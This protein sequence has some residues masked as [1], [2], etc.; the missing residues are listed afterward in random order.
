MN[1]R[2]SGPPAVEVVPPLPAQLTW[3]VLLGGVAV[4]AV[5][6]LAGI[7]IDTLA[8]MNQPPEIAERLKWANGQAGP[9]SQPGSIGEVRRIHSEIGR[10][11]LFATV[12]IALVAVGVLAVASGLWLRGGSDYR[13]WL[14]AAAGGWLGGFG[15]PMHWDSI[16][17][18]LW[19]AG[20]AAAAGGGLARLPVRWR[21]SLLA[22][23]VLF[24]FGSI[25]TAVTAPD[26]QGRS[27]WLSIMVGGR[28]YSSYSRFLYLGNAYHFY[29]PDPGPATQFVLL[30]EYEIDDPNEK[31]GK[32]TSVE[33]VTLPRRQANYRDPLGLTYFR[34]LSL[35]ELASSSLP[36][37][38]IPPSWEKAAVMQRRT[39]NELDKTGKQVVV[40]GATSFGEVDMTQYRQ[41]YSPIRRVVY[42]S[43]ARHIAAEYSGVRKRAD[44]RELPH[45]VTG[46]KL[47]RLEHRIIEAPQFLQYDD[48]EAVRARQRNPALDRST[49]IARGGVSVFDPPVYAPYYL[50]EYDADGRLKDPNDPLLYW[51]TPVRYVSSPGNGLPFDD[52]MSK[53]ARG[54]KRGDL[55]EGEGFPWGGKE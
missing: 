48:P 41:P 8:L 19:V 25:L 43:Y 51:L 37:T 26:T 10:T 39:Q 22:L 44:G 32:D 1:A 3:R 35:T 55:K 2:T 12:R 14:L 13:A 5:V 50:G 46:M 29:S 11:T 52:W 23:G 49:P 18:V 31:G 24:H 53:Y 7:A 20:T 6:G 40:P 54:V 45:R 42:P 4:C 36:G 38:A 33:W 16:K 9:E 30:I 47:F 21:F 34:R 15:L 28:V 17:L 27:S